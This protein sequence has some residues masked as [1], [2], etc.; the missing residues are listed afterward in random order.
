MKHFEELVAQLAL[1]HSLPTDGMVGILPKAKPV[2]T[3]AYTWVKSN[4]VRRAGTT[5][6]ADFNRMKGVRFGKRPN[7][8]IR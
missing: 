5:N 6:Q 2:P 4:A 1:K 8:T 3:I 7:F